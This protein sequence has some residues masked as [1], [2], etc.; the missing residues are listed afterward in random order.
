VSPIF[1]FQWDSKMMIY[2]NGEFVSKGL[3]TLLSREVFIRPLYDFQLSFPTSLLKWYLKP[4]CSILTVSIL[5][6]SLSERGSLHFYFTSTNLGP[7]KSTRKTIWEM[8]S[9]ANDRSSADE[10]N[11]NACGSKF[12]FSSQC[13]CSQ[14]V[15][16]KQERIRQKIEIF[17]S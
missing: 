5:L 17:S 14:V 8:E 2:S 4:K 7:S 9:S 1:Q 13:R 12:R 15:Q 10:C 16:I 6:S 3:R 11:F